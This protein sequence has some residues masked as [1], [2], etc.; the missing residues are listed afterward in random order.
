MRYKYL[1]IWL[2]SITALILAGCSTSPTQTMVVPT[3]TVPLSTIVETTLAPTDIPTAK[4]PETVE[5]TFTFVVPTNEPTTGVQASTGQGDQI[6]QAV[7]TVCH[8]SDRIMNSHKTQA[9]WQITVDRMI[10]YGAVLT[11]SEKQILIK[12]LSETCK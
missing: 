8:S 6:M 1:L 4:P 12:Y 2:T 9:E 10:S 7:C 3:V 5:P 11:D